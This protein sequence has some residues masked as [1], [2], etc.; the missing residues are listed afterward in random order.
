M[1]AQP[2]TS[3][4]FMDS[5]WN[6]FASIRLTVVVLISLA[7]LSAIGTLIPQNKSPV[8]Y[9][10][11]FGPF[12]YQVLAT[13]DIFDMYHSWWFQGLIMMLV[14]NIIVCSIDRL[15]K[16]WRI[17]FPGTPSFNLEQFRQR[18]SRMDFKV[19]PTVTQLESPYRA[20]IEKLFGGSRIEPQGAGYAITAEKG[21]WTRLGVYGVHLSIV[22]LLIGSLIGSMTGF[23]GY[24]NIPEG[25]STSTIQLR[26]T[27]ATMVLPFAIRCDDFEVQY[28]EGG[29]RPKEYRSS[30]TI[31]EN[32][33]PVLKKDIIV[34]DPLRY[35]GVAIY[36]SSFGNA[37]TDT[38]PPAP[39]QAPEKIEM[40]F[41]STASGMLYNKTLV[42]GQPVDLPE[43]LGSFVITEYQPSAEFKGMSLG[44]IFLGVLTPPAGE[45][46][47]IMLPWQFPKFDAMRQGNVVISVTDTLPQSETR[48]FTGLQ[49][50]SDPGVPLVYAGF[51]L[52]IAGCMVTFFMSHQRVVIEVQ[53]GAAGSEVMV[54][55]TS[56]KG[57]YQFQLKLERLADVLKESAKKTGSPA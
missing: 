44:P 40:T 14:I 36:Q 12:L 41:R 26:N 23:D 7:A 48:Y 31:L 20:R 15:R 24:V 43:G 37:D 22:V 3:P 1:N 46:E 27:G 35:K 38:A 34:N 8:E 47:N 39:A 10:E 21:R 55:G 30:L 28:Y 13:L 11:A 53:P 19:R 45:P 18:K 25:E 42:I 33:Q 50:N 56:N 16:T 9:F 4:G 51:I 17:I 5:L 29:R 54:A 49:V 6:F 32:G 2:E 57:K 52:M